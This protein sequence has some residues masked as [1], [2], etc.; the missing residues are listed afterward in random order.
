MTIAFVVLKIEAINRPISQS[1]LNFPLSSISENSICVPLRM[2]VAV[3]RAANR[4]GYT[5][6]RVEDVGGIAQKDRAQ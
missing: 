5:N 4:V 3:G 1:E 6:Q 2:W